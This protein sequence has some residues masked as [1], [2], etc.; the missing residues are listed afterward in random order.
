MKEKQTLTSGGSLCLF[1]LLAV[2]VSEQLHGLPSH[3]DLLEHRFEEGH[4][5]ELPVAGALIPSR[6]AAGCVIQ[7]LLIFHRLRHTVQRVGGVP[8]VPVVYW[9]ILVPEQT[10]LLLTVV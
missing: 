3:D 4:H 5:G 9:D 8:E 7:L 1:S 10:S 2:Q 6:A